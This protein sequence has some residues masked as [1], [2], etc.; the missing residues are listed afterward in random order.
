MD[1]SY[2]FIKNNSEVEKKNSEN[3]LNYSDNINQGFKLI[4]EIAKREKI[5]IGSPYKKDKQFKKLSFKEILKNVNK[6]NKDARR[7]FK[8]KMPKRKSRR[9]ENKLFSK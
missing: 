9:E 5:F 4:D 8:L 7:K 6:L 3:S 1:T 2:V